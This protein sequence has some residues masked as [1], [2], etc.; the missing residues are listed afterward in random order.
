MAARPAALASSGTM[1]ASNPERV[2]AL[3]L[4]LIRDAGLLQPDVSRGGPDALS[5]SE[6]FALSELSGR[7]LPQPDLAR[8]LHLEKSTVSRLVT[9]LQERGLVARERHP[10]NR[11]MWVVRL[12]DAGAATAQR[13]TDRYRLQHSALLKGLSTAEG[14]ALEVGLAALLRELSSGEAGG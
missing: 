13:V 10:D 9:V 2:H 12:T 8:R 14:R 3:L 4:Q 1:T 7:P 5:L 6:G 11:R